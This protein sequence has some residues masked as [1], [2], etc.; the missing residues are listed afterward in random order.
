[1]LGS[2]VKRKTAMSPTA[3]GNRARVQNAM[4]NPRISVKPMD[5]QRVGNRSSAGVSSF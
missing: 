4:A 3:A 2:E 1:M 5:T